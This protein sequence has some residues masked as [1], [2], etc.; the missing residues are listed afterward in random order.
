[1]KALQRKFGTKIIVFGKTDAT[2][3]AL[4]KIFYIFYSS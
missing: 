1:V 2:G 4:N 3:I